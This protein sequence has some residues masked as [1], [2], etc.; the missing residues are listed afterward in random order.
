M[1]EED[2]VV[3]AA[4][5]SPRTLLLSRRGDHAWVAA[6]RDLARARP[7]DLA[8]AWETLTGNERTRVLDV[9]RRAAPPPDLARD[10]RRALAGA[11]SDAEK[12]VIRTL[13]DAAPS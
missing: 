5:E 1:R 13:L 6:I 9:W 7:G 12:R 4:R 10:L 2:R 11:G 3:P 8:A